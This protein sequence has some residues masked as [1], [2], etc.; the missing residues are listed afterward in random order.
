M[1]AAWRAKSHRFKHW[2]LTLFVTMYGA[3]IT[4]AFDPLGEG[5]DGVRHL[6]HL[7]THY[8]GLSFEQFMS[9][10]SSIVTFRS[11]AAPSS[12]VFKHVLSYVVGG[13]LGLPWL[14]FPIVAFG[15]LALSVLDVVG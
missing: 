12:D 13:V 11:S 2:A 8:V 14:F 4:I 10:L 6:L 1:V 7:H 3:T 15:Q 9:E 5:P